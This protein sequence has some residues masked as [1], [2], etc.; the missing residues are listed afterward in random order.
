MDLVCRGLHHPTTNHDKGTVNSMNRNENTPVTVQHFKIGRRAKWQL[1]LDA[2]RDAAAGIPSDVTAEVP[3][4]VHRL[5]CQTRESTE[6][7]R[8]KTLEANTPRRI[9]I[10]EIDEDLAQAPTRPAEA[11][12]P[13]RAP[14]PGEEHLSAEAISYRRAR[15]H[16]ATRNALDAE[17]LPV[18]HRRSALAVERAVLTAAIAEQERSARS[19]GLQIH[20]HFGLRMSFYLLVL[21]R[22]HPKAELL[23]HL[24]GI[25]P[26]LADWVTGADMTEIRPGI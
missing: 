9:R 10:A 2:R 17:W 13:G 7:L 18:R 8:L 23:T 5:M 19:T 22:R 20:E 11:P 12:E 16:E 3:P 24:D 21:K 26:P 4:T 14:G 25:R 15:Q 1:A 6:N